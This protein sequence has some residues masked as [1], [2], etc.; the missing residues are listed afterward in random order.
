MDL[1]D[2][3]SEE[4]KKKQKKYSEIE[5]KL[6]FASQIMISNHIKAINEIREI[7]C[8]DL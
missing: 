6:E 8:F 4:L 2:L 7:L 1:L 3:Y 5:S